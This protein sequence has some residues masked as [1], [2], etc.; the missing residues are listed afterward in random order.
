MYFYHFFNFIC[1]F[2]ISSHRW[3]VWQEHIHLHCKV[4]GASGKK[5]FLFIHIVGFLVNLI[6][7]F[8]WFLLLI[9]VSTFNFFVY[10]VYQENIYTQPK[11]SYWKFQAGLGEGG[12]RW[13][14]NPNLYWPLWTKTGISRGVWGWFFWGEGS[15]GGFKPN[16]LYG[17]GISG[18]THC[19]TAIHQTIVNL[20][21]ILNTYFRLSNLEELVVN[22][23][24]LEVNLWFVLFTS[25]YIK[26]KKMLLWAYWCFDISK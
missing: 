25:R 19:F 24:E 12:G 21:F 17:R 7:E 23:N 6:S 4:K 1:S 2:F 18:T 16:N 5:T 8:L 11:G 15:G 9:S 13:G 10:C 20:C 22:H 3:L 14:Q 26:M